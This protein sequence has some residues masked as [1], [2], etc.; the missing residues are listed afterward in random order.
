LFYSEVGIP[1]SAA[2]WYDRV[3]AHDTDTTHLPRSM[4]IMAD[5]VRDR[6]DLH[7]TAPDGWYRRIV[8]EFPHSRYAAAAKEALGMKVAE[9]AASP[10]LAEFEE[11]EAQCDAENYDEAIRLLRQ[12][13]EKN[14]GSE[15]A[16]RSQYMIGWIYEQLVNEPDSAIA[17]YDTVVRDYGSTPYAMNLRNRLSSEIFET[18]PPDSARSDKDSVQVKQIEKERIML[19]E[20]QTQQTPAP[21]KKPDPERIE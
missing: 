11:A 20:R 1:D 7:A 6:P 21:Q 19:E 18:T 2:Y 9:G 15:V 8:N 10:A 4:F 14:K 16:A 12:I 5:I 17:H 13:A 3:L